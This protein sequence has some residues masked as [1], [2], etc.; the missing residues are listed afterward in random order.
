VV[1]LYTTSKHV[2]TLQFR[3]HDLEIPTRMTPKWCYMTRQTSLP[4]PV[5]P[6]TSLAHGFE[7]RAEG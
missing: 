4:D 3:F 6:V 2:H 1:D 5:Y 7:F